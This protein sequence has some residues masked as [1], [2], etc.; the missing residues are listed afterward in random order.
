MSKNNM[1]YSCG[2]CG[3]DFDGAIMNWPGEP[4]S[5]RSIVTICDY[6]LNAIK[7]QE[8]MLPSSVPLAIVG[9]TAG[10][11]IQLSEMVADGFQKKRAAQ[12]LRCVGKAMGLPAT[13]I[14]SKLAK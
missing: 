10:D 4:F 9:T 5:K 12:S 13:H 7:P 1:S 11:I 3:E 6:C 2:C 8:I 14:R